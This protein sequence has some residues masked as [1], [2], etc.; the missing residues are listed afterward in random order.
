MYY[1]MSA[2]VHK[3]HD[4]QAHAVLNMELFMPISL[5]VLTSGSIYLHGSYSTQVPVIER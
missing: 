3:H 1:Y 5:G 4:S 2:A